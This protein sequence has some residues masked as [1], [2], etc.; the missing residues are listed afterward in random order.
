M[1]RRTVCNGTSSFEMSGGNNHSTES[2]DGQ[3][4]EIF[5]KERTSFAEAK[6]PTAVTGSSPG[7]ELHPLLA[8]FKSFENGYYIS[9]GK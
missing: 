4:T 7:N 3:W 2:H 6:D 8:N 9:D 5:N 1:V